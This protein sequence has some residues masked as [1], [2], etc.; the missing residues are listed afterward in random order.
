MPWPALGRSDTDLTYGSVF[1]L[2]MAIYIAETCSWFCTQI[3]LCT[4]C[5]FVLFLF[6]LYMY[7]EREAC[8]AIVF[9]NVVI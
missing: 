9:R 2:M 6:S 3:K 8:G 5:D 7:Q 4:D 1:G